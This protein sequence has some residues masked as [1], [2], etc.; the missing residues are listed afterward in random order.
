M[1]TNETEIVTEKETE[2]KELVIICPNCGNRGKHQIRY[3]RE[4]GLPR[5]EAKSYI[6]YRCKHRWRIDENGNAVTIIQGAIFPK[7][8]K[9]EG[10]CNG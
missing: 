6:D 7:N 10:G 2:K 3:T 9:I 4:H 5:P 8:N 1:T